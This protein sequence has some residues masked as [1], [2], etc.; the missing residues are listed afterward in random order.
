MSNTL[1]TVALLNAGVPLV[2]R[3]HRVRH[4]LR[5]GAGSIRLRW[6]DK[7]VDLRCRQIGDVVAAA[8]ALQFTVDDY[9]GEFPLDRPLRLG[10][11]TIV[12]RARVEVSGETA[13]VLVEFRA[14][15]ARQLVRVAA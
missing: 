13:A 12:P 8:P 6:E 2:E 3:A 1:I 14:V 7:V 4:W 9:F 15:N 5:V 11:L 10:E